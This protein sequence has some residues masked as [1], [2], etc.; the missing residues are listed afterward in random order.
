MT[1][2]EKFSARRRSGIGGRVGFM[3]GAV[4]DEIADC[5]VMRTRSP[6]LADVIAR[7]L[8]GEDLDRRDV[9]TRSPLA[10]YQVA[11]DPRSECR[12]LIV[13]AES[14]IRRPSAYGGGI[15]ATTD[16]PALAETIGQAL[17]E[18]DP[19]PRGARHAWYGLVVTTRTSPWAG[20]VRGND[21]RRGGTSRRLPERSGTHSD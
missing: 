8:N 13:A 5:E 12:R 2:P 9:S 16:D 19:L 11:R 14:T 4:I 17:N 21:A 6:S 3:R 7:I 10:R 15:V 1:S 18:I 20:P